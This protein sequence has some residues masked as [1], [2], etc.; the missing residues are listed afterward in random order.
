MHA[1]MQ[2]LLGVNLSLPTS[3]NLTAH[4]DAVRA[5]AAQ[6][7]LPAFSMS[8][9]MPLPGQGSSATAAGYGPA[10]A[11]SGSEATH[12]R[13]GQAMAAKGYRARHPV[14]IIPGAQAPAKG[15]LGDPRVMRCWRTVLDAHLRLPVVGG[16]AGPACMRAC[17]CAEDGAR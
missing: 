3:L 9:P 11:G 13:A 10:G 4:L 5:V 2:G 16:R 6:L 1:C 14:V 8:L 7:P 12:A 15:W 17:T